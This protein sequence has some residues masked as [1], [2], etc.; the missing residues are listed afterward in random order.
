MSL[1]LP[2]NEL[3]T[4]IIHAK[5]LSEKER[6]ISRRAGPSIRLAST[7]LQA[8]GFCSL[9]LITYLAIGLRL[10]IA[11]RMRIASAHDD[12]LQPLC[13]HLNYFSFRPPPVLFPSH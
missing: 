5:L 11:I 7:H 1:Y 2:A 4:S 12:L 10:A 9:F 3:S 8:F 13:A 6:P